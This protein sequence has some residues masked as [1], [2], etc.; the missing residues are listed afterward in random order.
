MTPQEITVLASLMEIVKSLSGWPFALFFL[1]VIIGPWV[2]A[3]LLMYAFRK[4]FEEVVRMYEN[5]VSL[6]DKYELIAKDMKSVVIAN[7]AAITRVCDKA[8]IGG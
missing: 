5:N 8:G 2:F 6:V 4:R 7:T 1:V 3:M